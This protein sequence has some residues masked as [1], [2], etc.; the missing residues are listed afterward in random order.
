MNKKVNILFTATFSTPFIQEDLTILKTHFSVTKVI[1]SGI[2]TFF[3]YF[4]AIRSNDITFSW[5]ASVYSS[6][7]VFLTKVFRKKSILI[8]GGVDVARIPELKYGIWNSWWRSIIVR[9][10]VTN[11]DLVLAVDES[12]KNDAVR[13]A[14]YDGNNIH[15]LPTGYDSTRWKPGT[16]QENIVLTV[17]N[18]HN[19]TRVKIKGIDFLI[20]VAN[21]MPDISFVLIGLKNEIAVQLQIPANIKYYESLEQSKLLEAY[22]RAKIFFQPSLREGLP[23]TLC[24]AMLCGCFPVGTNVGGIPSAIGDT[25]IIVQHNDVIEATNALHKAME[26]HGNTMARDRI[27]KFYSIK[28]REELLM[29]Y[30]SSLINEK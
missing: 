8:L 20:D 6:I 3:I 2:K 29:K 11:A 1:S 15:V 10:G 24:E 14:G 27:M 28:K 16:K 7:L 23:N 5:F 21:T 25:G 19:M 12:L 26:H 17:A 22:Q 30:I 13:L 9:Y 18:C 4:S